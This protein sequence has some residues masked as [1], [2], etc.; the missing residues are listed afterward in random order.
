MVSRDSLSDILKASIFLIVFI[1][2]EIKITSSSLFLIM[3]CLFSWITSS[4][5]DILT[6][7]RAWSNRCWESGKIKTKFG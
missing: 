6:V 4:I 3:I 1:S 5:I 2:S 7:K